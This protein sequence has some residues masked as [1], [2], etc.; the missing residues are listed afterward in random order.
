MLAAHNFLLK[1]PDILGYGVGRKQ[2][3]AL[4]FFPETRS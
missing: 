1:Y 2:L 4:F 3:T